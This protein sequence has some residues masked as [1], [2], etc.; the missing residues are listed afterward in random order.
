MIALLINLRS[1]MKGRV[2]VRNYAANATTEKLALC[3]CESLLRAEQR[4]GRQKLSEMVDR[5]PAKWS[6]ERKRMPSIDF[7]P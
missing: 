1:P 5:G 3:Q 2:K 4:N 6:I 7:S